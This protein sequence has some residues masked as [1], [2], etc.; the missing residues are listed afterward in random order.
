[1]LICSK[2]V[3]ADSEAQDGRQGRGPVT[4]VD[5]LAFLVGAAGVANRYLEDTGSALGQLD[6][7][8]RLEPEVV[9]YERNRAQ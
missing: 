9:R 7:Q 2:E 3:V 5:L 1:M 4:P 8:L 6:D